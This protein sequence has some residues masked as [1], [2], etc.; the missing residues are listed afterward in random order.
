M[1][2]EV[3]Q[4]PYDCV[5]IGGGPTG[6]FGA[7]YAGMRGMRTL[8]V[9]SVDRL[10]GQPIVLYPE[11]WIYDVPGFVKVRADD[12]VQRLITQGFSTGA[13]FRT[14]CTVLK[15]GREDDLY[16]LDLADGDSVTARGLLIATGIGAFQ[17]RQHPLDDL[18]AFEGRGVTYG[19]KKLDDVRG[20]R[21]VVIGGGDA[22][23]DWANMA[24]EVASS[25]SIVHRRKAF[26][27]VE[28]SVERLHRSGVAIM[29]P[30]EITGCAGTDRITSVDIH[31][32]EAGTTTT[33]PCDTVIVSLGYHSDLGPVNEWGLHIEKRKIQVDSTMQTNLERIYAAGDVVDYPGK[34][35]LIATGF[36]EAAI[37]INHL[38]HD[39]E[40]KAAIQPARSSHS[41][42]PAAG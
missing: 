9:E 42:R 12:L 21:V 33:V 5:I 27:G 7:F 25:V 17:P 13:D 35:D 29:T 24:S 41:G 4:T 11:K 1:D 18:T 31:N 3:S 20:Q 34:I 22:A 30:S 32:S 8:V 40:P 23:L 28:E 16:R 26:R 38:K 10:G 14:G 6:L 15:V 19:I 2:D 39:F 36:S 37:A